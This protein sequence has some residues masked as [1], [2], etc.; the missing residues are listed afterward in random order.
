[1]D[2]EYAA[3][4]ADLYRRHW[5]WR[6][7]EHLV[8][9]TLQQTMDRNDARIL[10]VG[11]GDAL[12]WPKLVRFGEVAGIEPDGR[13]VSPNNPDCTRIEV[14]GFL[15]AKE[16]RPAHDLLLMLDV[17]EHIEDESAALERVRELL[18]PGGLYVLTVP[19]FMWLWS[20][21]DVL[22]GHFRRYT[23][24]SLRRALTDAGFTVHRLHYF[25]VWTLVPLLLRKWFY[26]AEP[27][28]ESAFLA[29]PPRALNGLLNRW[30]RL[31]NHLAR[32]V[33][34]PGGS[35]LIAVAR[36]PR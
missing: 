29:V 25:F 8:L 27:D 16:P 3:R 1:M 34:F 13:L 5:W 14:A 28:E 17:L 20:H 4:Y 6:A 26:R 21:H 31:E 33:P 23:A 19:A 15:E 18:R 11:C 24:R 10:D 35:S 30:C 32:H 9:A 2:A 12:L 7:R 36:A 22:N